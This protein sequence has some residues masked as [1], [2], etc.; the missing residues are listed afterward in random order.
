MELIEYAKALIKIVFRFKDSGKLKYFLGISDT[1]QHRRLIGNLLFL[2]I[3]RPYIAYV[4]K[5]I[6]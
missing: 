3:I 4:V 1:G 6:K 2:T 5:K